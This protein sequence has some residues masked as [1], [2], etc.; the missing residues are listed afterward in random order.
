MCLEFLV[1]RKFLSVVVSFCL[2]N[3]GFLFSQNSDEERRIAGVWSTI[4]KELDK[5]KGDT[6]RQVIYETVF[7]TCQGQRSCTIETFYQVM[8]KLERR[9]N[10]PAAI[11]VAE[12]IVKLSKLTND[13]STEAHAYQNLARYHGALGNLKSTVQNLEKALA[14]YEMTGNQSSILHTKVAI[15]E[16]S[17]NYRQAEEVLKELE[18]ILQQ[19]IVKGDTTIVNYLHLRLLIRTQDLQLYNKMEQHIIA[20]EK[21]PLSNPIKPNEFGEAIHAALGRADLFF[22]RNDL[23]NAERYYQKTLRLCQQ[24]PSRWLEI[25]VLQ[26]LAGLERKRGQV[27]LAKAYLLKA[28][29]KA[30]ALQLDELLSEIYAKRAE[31]AEQEANYRDALSFT[32][33]QFYHRSKFDGHRAGFN[34]ET[35]SLQQE[36]ERLRLEK[37]G[38]DL[39]LQLRSTQLR[40]TLVV[41]LLVLLLAGGLLFGYTQQSRARRKLGLQNEII[42]EQAQ[43]LKSLD[44]AKMQF[45]ANVSH[46]LRT[47]LTLVLGPVSTLMK[48]QSLPQQQKTLL[49][50][51]Y[52]N[53]RQ[54]ANLV[55]EILDLAKLDSGKM[56]LTKKPLLLEPFFKSN[57]AQFVSYV[58]RKQIHY[59][60]EV[61]LPKNFSVNVDV[62]KF[63]QII[64]NLVSNALKF[65]PEGGQI[66]CHL[67]V[68]GHAQQGETAALML[69]VANTGPQI[70]SEDL[71]HIFDRFVQTYYAERSAIEGTGI[72]LALCK[73]YATLFGGSIKVENQEEH[74]VVFTVTFPVEVVD[75]HLGELST[76]AV[77]S[78]PSIALIGT[79]SGL[80][81][82]TS[83]GM[84]MILIVEDNADLQEYLQQILSPR[85]KVYL[86]NNGREALHFL[87][88]AEESTT[89]ELIL[90]DV[91]MPEMD[92]FQ[93]LQC[94]KADSKLQQI[95]VI[96]LTARAELDDRLKALRIGV[97]DYLNKP[98][99][100]EELLARIDNLLSNYRVRREAV[101]EYGQEITEIEA[102][103][104]RHQ[105][106]EEFELYVRQHMDNDTLNIPELA[107]NFAMSESTLL[108][109]LKRLTG[110]TPVQYV[111]ELRLEH[112]RNLLESNAMDSVAKVA[113][114]VGYPN[115]RSFAR[116]FTK[117]YGRP[118]SS[119]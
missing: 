3:C 106:L 42:Q 15:I 28:Q 75:E 55:N 54:L 30:E 69:T 93:L 116:I 114:A 53:G 29:G 46:E 67:T 11:F 5:P 12:E 61:N 50:T 86:A 68:H 59:V 27:E 97:D 79:E 41:T 26:S 92:G 32:Q 1:K 45:F 117:R 112:A 89:V 10:L 33:L 38:K 99:E 95:P 105:W 109:Q 85:F 8:I 72:G 60:V 98:F 49:E 63:R 18:D 34:L 56:E 84:P 14:I 40:T 65:T 57:T 31:I 74:G 83:A 87:S 62:E 100:E 103:I 58:D 22:V 4:Q 108:R 64:A 101:I 91:M 76:E 6:C 96:M 51:A 78:A 81:M 19:A 7:A 20:L 43:Q 24:E 47:P 39:Q 111:L 71:P 82:V 110:L 113:A 48:E 119:Y 13:L 90:T 23:V 88:N 77:E 80:E 66:R 102:G 104:E 37:Q 70:H 2:L 35:Y 44:T 73:E 52:K 107:R 115:V 21:I 94:L 16:Q 36:N 17:A 25:K 9:F 118:P